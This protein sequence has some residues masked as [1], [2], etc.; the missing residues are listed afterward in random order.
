MVIGWLLRL[1]L[2]LL[3]IRAL[4][5]FL[6][7]LAAG[8]GGQEVGS[9]SAARR[10]GPPAR[11][12]ALVRDPVCGMFVEPSHALTIRRGGTTYHFCSD[13]CLQAFRKAS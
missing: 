7:G 1:L 4:W 13:G 3:I 9:R 2:L 8:V 11:G 6:A 10:R 12:V 5:S